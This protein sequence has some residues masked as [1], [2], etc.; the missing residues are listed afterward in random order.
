MTDHTMTIP[1][2]QRRQIKILNI[3]SVA[4]SFQISF[5]KY[6]ISGWSAGKAAVNTPPPANMNV[7]KLFG[8]F[9]ES[10]KKL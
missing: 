2:K 5:N 7:H 10:L 4:L 9:A 6:N 3:T 8:Q 1:G